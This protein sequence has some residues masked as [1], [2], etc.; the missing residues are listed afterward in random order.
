MKVNFQHVSSFNFQGL[1]PLTPRRAALPVDPAGGTSPDCSPLWPRSIIVKIR[2]SQ[3]LTLTLTLT[4][5][6]TLGHNPNPRCD[7]LW[8]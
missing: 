5:T 7:R 3:T 8:L 6:P 4:L 2:Y 1:S